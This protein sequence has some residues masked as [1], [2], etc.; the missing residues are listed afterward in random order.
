M[1]EYLA[2]R[3]W[4][5][6]AFIVVC[7]IVIFAILIRS[8]VDTYKEY[9]PIEKKGP[10][11]PVFVFLL[12]TL[13]TMAFAALADQPLYVPIM[14]GAWLGI[15]AAIYP[16]G[17]MTYRGTTFYVLKVFGLAALLISAH[18]AIMLS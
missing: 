11:F 17:H 2:D 1:F 14:V 7:I 3:P 15:S 4:L 8:R 10:W 12:G 16:K 13:L 9:G 6:L 5:L 18:V